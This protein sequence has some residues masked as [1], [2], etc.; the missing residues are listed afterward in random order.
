MQDAMVGAGPVREAFE[1]LDRAT[2]AVAGVLDPEPVLQVI[3]DLVRPLVGARYAALGIVGPDGMME[4]FITSGIDDE[5]RAAIGHIPQ[6]HGF[7]GL[8]IRENRT[9]LVRDVMADP[10]S[11]RLPAEPPGDAQLPGRRR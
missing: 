8:I 3:V 1:A 6:G 10:A 9:I 5:T 7:L 4:R 11:S 2:R